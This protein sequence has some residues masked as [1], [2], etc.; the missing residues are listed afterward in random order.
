MTFAENTG[1]K[2]TGETYYA[3][4]ETRIHTRSALLRSVANRVVNDQLALEAWRQ[5]QAGGFSIAA[6]GGTP[7]QLDGHLR[8]RYIVRE[9]AHMVTE[10]ENQVVD[11]GIAY[12]PTSSMDVHGTAMVLRNYVTSNCESIPQGASD[13]DVVNMAM[14]LLGNSWAQVKQDAE[15]SSFPEYMRIQLDI[16]ERTYVRDN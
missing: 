13:V 12:A 11:A 6:V 15:F 4:K 2:V 5:I 8:D 10:G 9:L 7:I 16:M 3:K 14:Q 1:V